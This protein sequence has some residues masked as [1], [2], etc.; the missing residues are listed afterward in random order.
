MDLTRFADLD[1]GERIPP[2]TPGDVLLYEFMEP[3]GLSARKLA[4]A[5]NAPPNRLTGIIRGERG[6]TAKTAIALGQ[7][8]GTS[9]EFWMNLQT[10]Y[11]LEVARGQLA[12]VA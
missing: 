3:M 1:S 2:V 9:A 8:F 12:K 4:R 5:L 10:A 6:V 7:H 11:D